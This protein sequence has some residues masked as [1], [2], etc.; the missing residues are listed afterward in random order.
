MGYLQKKS[1][2][3]QWIITSQDLECM[4]AHLG[5]EISLWCDHRIEAPT[6][7]IRQPSVGSTSE[8]SPA[9]RDH[10]STRYTEGELDGMATEL[11]GKHR[12][13]FLSLQTVGKI[14]NLW[15]ACRQI[16]CPKCTHDYWIVF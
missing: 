11:K 1:Q 8:A 6:G 9:K 13:R 14:N 12:N 16:E 15:T 2:A 3:K 5:E 7:T 10:K 4:Y